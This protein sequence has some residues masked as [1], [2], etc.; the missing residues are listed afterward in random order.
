MSALDVIESENECA[1]I[2]RLV[3][4]LRVYLSAA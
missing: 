2:E 3:G 4:K 1:V